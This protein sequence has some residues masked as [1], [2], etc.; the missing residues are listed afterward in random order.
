MKQRIKLGVVC[1]ARETYDVA[2]AASLY[3]KIRADLLK[4]KEVDLEMVPE[5]VISIDE[6]KK[7]ARL[8]AEACVDG[9]ICISGTFHLGHLVLEFNKHLHVPILLWG[10]DELPYNGGKIRL[11]S[12]CGINLDASNLYKA[13]V[14]SYKA[15]VGQ[16]IDENWV[17][18][19]RV[20]VAL[21]TAH[22]GLLGYRANGF[23]NLSLDD[24]SLYG[25]TGI[26]IDHYELSDVY[27]MPVAS[28][29]IERR[30]AQI[31]SIFDVSGITA[32]QVT[33]VAEL[34]AKLAAFYKTNKLNAVAIRCWPEFARDFGIAPCA[35]MSLLQS[36]GMILA[37]EGDLEG[38]L[39]MIAH[40][41]MGAETPY[42]FD[43]SQ[44]NFEENFALLWHDGVAPCNLRDG[45]SVCSLDSYFANGKGVTADF[46][47]KPGRIS[48]ARI[49]TARGKRRL[50]LQKATGVPM[51][52]ELKGTYLKVIFDRPVK[53]VLD[54][55]L[56]NGI[57]HHA[58]MVYGDYI[59]PLKVAAEIMSWEVIE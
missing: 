22:V 41:A 19:I 25:T 32:A 11:N 42:L 26:L 16:K 8:M 44:F 59:Q 23:F 50:F 40:Q 33:K 1:L 55:V 18:A 37:C 48:I 29:E 49:D 39:S 54:L 56:K 10:L 35:A 3:E 30:E 9:L 38:A 14:N 5:L 28:S 6:A 36:E 52:K 24:S 53:E 45:H 43:F 27:T 57:A 34:S 51:E 17:D 12:V 21:R 13:G 4:L 46:V 31:R 15:F 20:L 47:L 2:A 7:N 58:S